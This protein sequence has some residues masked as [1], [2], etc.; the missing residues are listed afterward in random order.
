MYCV[1]RTQPFRVQPHLY[2]MKKLLALTALSGVLALSAQTKWD[3]E[4][5][6]RTPPPQGGMFGAFWNYQMLV[7]ASPRAAD[8]EA[9]TGRWSYRLRTGQN[10][11]SYSQGP[12]SKNFWMNTTS[13]LGFER[14]SR[15]GTRLK[16]YFGAELGASLNS[17]SSLN[18][19]YATYGPAASLLYGLRYR[20]KPR[21]TL[22]A[23]LAPS[24]GMW[25]SKS[26]GTWQESMTNIN[27]SGQ[28]LGLA[29]TYRL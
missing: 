7:K 27:I 26:N 13:M 18:G 28:S 4:L 12:N 6:L 1:H 3:W 25:F 9:G 10:T 2:S 19:S 23:E 24:I 14:S 20:I 15:R 22:S 11:L 16:S 17:Y 8:A 21:W 5:G 29:A